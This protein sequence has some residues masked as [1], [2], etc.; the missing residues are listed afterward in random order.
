M[1]LAV[2]KEHMIYL[3]VN[4]PSLEIFDDGDGVADI[5]QENKASDERRHARDVGLSGSDCAEC[6]L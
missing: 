6:I 4:A 2:G 3:G 5:D 1:N